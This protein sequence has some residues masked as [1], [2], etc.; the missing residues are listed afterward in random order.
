[1]PASLGV[2]LLPARPPA[3]LQ[4]AC[5]AFKA[6]RPLGG[7]RSQPPVL[8]VVDALARMVHV[9]RIQAEG[10]LPGGGGSMRW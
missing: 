6:R 9:D 4:A 7:E 3:L 10:G 2:L 5:L 8:Q 1:V